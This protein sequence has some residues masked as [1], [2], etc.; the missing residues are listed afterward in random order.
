M[1][2]AYRVVRGHKGGTIPDYH[3]PVWLGGSVQR[4]SLGR[5]NVHGYTRWLRIVCNNPDCEFE[6]LIN[7]EAALREY[8]G[9]GISR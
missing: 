4:D 3:E 9:E 6:A 8:L 1:R 2:R 7:P 5:R